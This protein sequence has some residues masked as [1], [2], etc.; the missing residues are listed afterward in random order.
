MSYPALGLSDVLCLPAKKKDFNDTNVLS[1]FRRVA[2]VED[3]YYILH[4]VHCQERWHKFTSPS[5]KPKTCGKRQCKDKLNTCLHETTKAT[6][7]LGQPP[8]SSPFPGATTGSVME[9]AVSDILAA[10]TCEVEEVGDISETDDVEEEVTDISDKEPASR[11]HSQKNC[12]SSSSS[13]S[14]GRSKNRL[15]NKPAW[16]FCWPHVL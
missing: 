4:R 14:L 6:P 11:A 3:F 10:D 1:H 7:Y 2:H 12:S 9:E 15:G 16:Q 8:H 13:S 5:S